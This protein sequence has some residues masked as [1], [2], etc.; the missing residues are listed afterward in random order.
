M[1]TNEFHILTKFDIKNVGQGHGGER[2]MAFDHKCLNMYYGF[3]S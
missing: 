1:K 3:F 2:L